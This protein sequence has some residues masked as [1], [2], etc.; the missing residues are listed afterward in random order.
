MH[1][2]VGKMISSELNAALAER[3]SSAPSTCTHKGRHNSETPGRGD[4][5]PSIA[6]V[7][8]TQKCEHTNT[9]ARVKYGSGNVFSSS[10]LLS[11]TF[12][13]MESLFLSYSLSVLHL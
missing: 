3:Q 6:S 12:S 7:A 13:T 5:T 10:M 11:L 1:Y 2:G 8:P 4:L 9:H